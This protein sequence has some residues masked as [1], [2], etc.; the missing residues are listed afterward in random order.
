[1]YINII[2]LKNINLTLHLKQIIKLHLIGCTQLILHNLYFKFCALVEQTNIT[3]KK[4]K[5]VI[6]CNGDG[7]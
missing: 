3:Q 2:L 6:M 7:N 1:M 5:G 4:K